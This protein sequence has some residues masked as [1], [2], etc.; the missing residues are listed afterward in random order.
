MARRACDGSA[1]LDALRAGVANLEAHVDE[2]NGLNVYPVPDGDTGS[3]MMATVRAALVE[4]EP[5]GRRTGRSDRRGDQLRCPDGRARQLGRHHQPD[6]P[7]HGRGSGRRSAASTASTSPTRS[8]RARR[9]AYGAVAKPVEGTILTVIR[10]SA[11]AAVAA[12]EHDND[13]ESVLAAALDA[14][15]KAVARTPSPPADPPRGRRRRRGRPGSLPPLPGRP[16]PPPRRRA[17]R[18]GAGDRPAAAPARAAALVAHADEG[19]GYETMFLL[20]PAAG[21]SLDLDAIR[22]HLET[23]GESVL[24]AG[25]GR[26]AKVHVHNER[27]DQV[28]AYGLGLGTLSRISVENLDNQARDVREARAAE[29]TEAVPGQRRSPGDAVDG[30]HRAARRRASSRSSPATASQRSSRRSGSTRSSTAGSRPT[31]APASC[32]SVAR[33]ARP[34]RSSSCRT[35]RTSVLAAEQAASMC[36]DKPRRGRADTERRRG[37]R[38]DPRARSHAGRGRERRADD[39]GRAGDP[40]HPGHGGRA[41]RDDRRA[42]GQEGPDDRRS[43]PTTASSPPTTTASKAVLAGGRRRSSPASSSSRSTTATAPTWPRPR[44]WR[45]RSARSSPASEVEVVHGGQPH[46]RYLIS[47][48]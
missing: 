33:L 1:L 5:R 20:Q 26:A 43:I 35:T 34:A 37:P 42:Q 31:R 12:A 23:I 7:G 47:A 17:G 4:A 48:E 16:A 22:G 14:A 44:R 3:N 24:V 18:R 6:L 45:A 46:Y 8:R 36:D 19:F 9:T 2:I 40:E 13:I 41:R 11:A 38:R 25:D 32:S 28:L 30:R 29:F 21:Q 15:E 27:P 10:E 39:R